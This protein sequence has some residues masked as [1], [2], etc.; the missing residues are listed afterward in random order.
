MNLNQEEAIF[1]SLRAKLILGLFGHAKMSL[2]LDEPIADVLD[3]NLRMTTSKHA[4]ETWNIEGV[5]VCLQP[6]PNKKSLYIKE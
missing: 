5:D 2:T 3:S 1:G 4:P 6:T